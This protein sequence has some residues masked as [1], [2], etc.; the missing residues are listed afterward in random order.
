MPILDI[1][2]LDP[3]LQSSFVKHQLAL[4]TSTVQKFSLSPDETGCQD[5]CGLKKI[6]MQRLKPHRTPK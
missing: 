5:Y 3:P 4:L 6:M 2:Q 1:N